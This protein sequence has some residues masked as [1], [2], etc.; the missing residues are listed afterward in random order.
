[1]TGPE[2]FREAEKLLGYA[3]NLDAEQRGSREDMSY[4]TEALVHATLAK[5]AANAEQAAVMAVAH[6]INSSTVDE[7]ADVLAKKGG[8]R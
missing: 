1:M 5:A 8:D 3:Q 7:W 2:H 6:D 4:L